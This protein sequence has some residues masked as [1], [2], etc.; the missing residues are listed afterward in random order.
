MGRSSIFSTVNY[1]TVRP[2][3]LCPLAKAALAARHVLEVSILHSTSQ[4]KRNLPAR[5]RSDES[6]PRTFPHRGFVVAAAAIIVALTLHRR[7]RLREGLLFLVLDL[8]AV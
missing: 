4:Q 7:I 6:R 3:A 1:V 2:Q 5:P 8:L